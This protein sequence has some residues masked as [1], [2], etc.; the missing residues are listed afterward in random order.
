MIDGLAAS[1]RLDALHKSAK[2]NLDR[3]LAVERYLH[4][5]YE[6]RE[7]E[8][9]YNPEVSTLL[10]TYRVGG[11]N[12]LRNVVETVK[13]GAGE[14]PEWKANGAVTHL[15]FRGGFFVLVKAA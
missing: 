11:S 13:R 15:A 12:A 2:A 4:A 14:L 8:T 7:V 1:E 3:A 6:A 10:V 5:I 9:A